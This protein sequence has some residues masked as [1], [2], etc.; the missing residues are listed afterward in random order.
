MKHLTLV[1]AYG[2]DYQTAARAEGAWIA[3]KDWRMPEGPYVGIGERET[4]LAQGYTS[5]RLRYATLTKAID[6]S[7]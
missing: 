4:L 6:V 3:G 5:V 7:L 2:R 1:P